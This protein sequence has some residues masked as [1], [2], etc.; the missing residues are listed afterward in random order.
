[1]SEPA[2][3]PNAGWR[4]D[5]PGSAG[6]TKREYA[7]IHIAA[8]L[9]SDGSMPSGAVAAEATAIVEKLGFKEEGGAQ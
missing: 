9:A 7:L 1:M 4:D 2:F 3:P 6:L 8:G 5:Q